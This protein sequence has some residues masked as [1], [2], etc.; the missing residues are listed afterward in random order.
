[1]AFDEDGRLF[2]A[3]M[4]GYPNGGV[5][6]GDSRPAASSSSRTA[7]ATA[8]SRRPR[9]SPTACASRSVLPWQGGL[10]VA[11]APDLLFLDPRGQAPR[12]LHRLRPRQHPAAGQQPAVGPRQLGLRRAPAA[13]AATITLRR[14]AGRAAGRRCA[15]AASASSPTCPAAW[16]RPPA[17]GS[18]ASPPTTGGHWFTATNSQHLRHIVLPD[19]YLRRNP[20]LPVPAVTLDIPDHGAACKVFRIS[21]FEAWR[22]ERTTRRARTA[23]TPSA[24]PR[25]SWSPAASSP[26]RAARSSTPPTC[27]RRSTAATSSSAT[28]PTT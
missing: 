9:R 13:T 10:L 18:T 8:S 12:P 16:S 23:P 3:E 17:A 26:R 24:S 4:R 28:R 14:E 21:P 27:S 19:H 15:A 20:Y 6:T 11:N 5:G 1:M 22:V 2:V 25:P 7:T